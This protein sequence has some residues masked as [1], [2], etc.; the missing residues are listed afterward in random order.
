MSKINAE[1]RKQD[2]EIRR[3]T[4]ARLGEKELPKYPLSELP[5]K[6][7]F[8]MYKAELGDN[9]RRVGLREMV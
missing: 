5:N 8:G 4:S 1:M 3:Y 6:K 9:D 2:M 7:K